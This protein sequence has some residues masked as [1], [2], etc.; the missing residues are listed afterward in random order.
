M[1]KI[2]LLNG[3]AGSGK[4]TIG[5]FLVDKLNKAGIYKFADPIKKAVAALFDLSPEEYQ[6]YFETQQGKNNPSPRFNNKTPREWLISFSED[7]AKKNGGPQIFGKIL[8]DKLR[9]NFSS[10]VIESAVVTDSGFLP[11]AEAVLNTFGNEVDVY[12]IRL[13]RT[14]Y[15]FD[16][17][18]RGYIHLKEL[19]PNNVVELD[20]HNN[21][22]MVIH[23]VD[24]IVNEIMWRD[25]LY[26][27][28]YINPDEQGW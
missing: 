8:G 9:T 27:G 1:N 12:L 19:F 17:D 10:G 6:F 15:K 13:N 7:F 11:E 18:S 26:E 24:N 16:G 5:R 20:V 3:P 25:Q 14:G 22:G 23:S 28:G 21:E 2:I 4:D